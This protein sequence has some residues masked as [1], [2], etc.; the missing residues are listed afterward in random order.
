MYSTGAIGSAGFGYECL[1]AKGVYTLFA[2]L[3]LKL[4]IHLTGLFRISSIWLL[5]L[6]QYHKNLIFECPSKEPLRSASLTVAFIVLHPV[7]V[8]IRTPLFVPSS[9]AP[10]TL[11]RPFHPPH[12]PSAPLAPPSL[13]LP[14]QV[15]SLSSWPPPSS[16]SSSRSPHSPH[17]C[18]ALSSFSHY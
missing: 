15:F 18:P 11:P 5:R 3:G 14:A 17:H 1:Q 8:A 9:K 6:I 13:V 12:S 2:T 4:T 10:P 16:S 7:F